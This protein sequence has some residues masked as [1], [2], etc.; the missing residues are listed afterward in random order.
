MRRMLGR[1]LYA[2]CSAPLLSFV[3]VSQACADFPSARACRR[4]RVCVR[5][6]QRTP[7]AAR[8][9]ARARRRAPSEERRR[10]NPGECSPP[11]AA[12][13]MK[14]IGKCAGWP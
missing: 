7:A 13:D 9:R 4:V 3:R 8:R 6:S 12:V 11:H 10:A 2:S 1:P 14:T 5:E